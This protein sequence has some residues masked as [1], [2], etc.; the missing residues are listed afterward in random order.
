MAQEPTA[1]GP[2]G[3]LVIRNI[4]LLLTGDLEKPIAEGCDTLVA[5]D[6]KI[7]AFGR[8]K[9]CDTAGAKV[10]V[11]ANGTALS[12]GLIDSHVH[13]V[14]GNGRRGRTSSVGSRAASMAAS[15]P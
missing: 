14:A 3:K 10:V 1:G 15:P 11:D 9:D 5:V 8:E 12:P 7:V 13:P 6:G 2:A 4:G